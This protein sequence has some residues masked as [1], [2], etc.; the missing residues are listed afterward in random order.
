M[1]KCSLKE[2]LPNGADIRRA[3]CRTEEVLCVRGTELAE[4]EEQEDVA[5]N[6]APQTNENASCDQSS[7]DRSTAAQQSTVTCMR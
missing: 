4:D 1:L 6:Y 7:P 3:F 5:I 2:T